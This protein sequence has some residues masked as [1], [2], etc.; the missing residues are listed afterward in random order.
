[1]APIVV[2]ISGANRG[3]GKGLLKR[4]LAQPDH[5]IIAANR[6]PEHQTSKDLADLPAASGSCVIVVKLDAVAESGAADAVEE[7]RAKHGIE[8]L[9]IVIANAG[10]SYVWPSVA[11]AK[12]EDM[13]GHMEP[14]VYGV[15]RLYQATRPL[16]KKSEKEPIF[17]PMGS[18]A[19]LVG[20]QQPPIPNAAYGPSKAALS[21]ITVRINSEDD[22][23]NAFVLCP[24]WVQTDLGD[25]GARGLGLKEAPLGLDESCD[26]VMKMLADSTKEKH[27]GK[28]VWYDGQVWDW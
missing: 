23:L 24:G 16:L 28:L 10:V 2:L 20:R 27:G 15:V 11:D 12:I 9:N 25:A 7:L 26:G 3:L 13:R 1:M 22:W 4:Y 14:N 19:G 8:H 17:T 6:D 21:W 5:I 18:T